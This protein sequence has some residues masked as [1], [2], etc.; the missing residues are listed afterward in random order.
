MRIITLARPL[1]QVFC[2]KVTIFRQKIKIDHKDLPMLA[3]L[4]IN[5]GCP[6][7]ASALSASS[8]RHIMEKINLND[9]ADELEMMTEQALVRFT[10]RCMCQTI[11]ASGPGVGLDADQALDVV[12]IEY[13]RRGIEKH[14]DIAAESVAKNPDWCDAA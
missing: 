14:Y 5:E 6:F 11:H 4:T 7:A 9:L 12:Y 1:R 10:K 2:A 13:S 8:E 3:D